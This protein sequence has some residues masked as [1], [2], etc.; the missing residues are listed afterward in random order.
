MLQ[1]GS[2][3]SHKE[4]HLLGI[5]TVLLLGSCW[6]VAKLCAGSINP[7]VPDR[8][9]DVT[10]ECAVVSELLWPPQEGTVVEETF[11]CTC[12]NSFVEEFVVQGAFH[13][14][15]LNFLCA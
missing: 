14:L 11:I 2:L 13:I 4:E 10:Q 7:G 3:Y 15:A 9:R 12:Q 6:N 1:S 5:L 8:V